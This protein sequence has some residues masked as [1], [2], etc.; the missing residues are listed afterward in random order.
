MPKIFRSMLT[1]GDKPK[2]GSGGKLLGVRVPPD[3]HADITT[4]SAGNVHPG[5]GGMSVAPDW[6]V[7]PAHLIPRRLKH[8]V[9]DAD[10][11][12]KL[13]CW[14][15]GEGEFKADAV[16]PDVQLRPDPVHPDRHGFVEPKRSM[17]LADYQSALAATRDQWRQ[18]E[19]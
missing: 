5:A 18:D 12:N 14:T 13:T 17:T 10:G 8:V 7:L 6:R 4:D 19:S 15:L 3:R 1:E 9:P 11:N 2:V 16:A